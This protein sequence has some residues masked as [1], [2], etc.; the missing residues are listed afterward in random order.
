MN[1]RRRIRLEVIGTLAAVF[2]GSM[3]IAFAQVVYNQATYEYRVE[4]AC[5]QEWI[6]L[7]IERK[8]ITSG[9]GTC[10]YQRTF[11]EQ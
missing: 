11:G 1:T 3:I 7:G 4:A 5:I 10:S 8:H 2:F 6:D 9:N